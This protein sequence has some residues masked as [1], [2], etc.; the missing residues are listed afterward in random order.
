MCKQ[1]MKNFRTNCDFNV[2]TVKLAFTTIFLHKSI[3][4]FL[5]MQELLIFLPKKIFLAKNM[6]CYAISQGYVGGKWPKQG[7]QKKVSLN[8]HYLL[9]LNCEKRP[10]PL[11]IRSGNSIL[12]ETTTLEFLS[13][14]WWFL[15]HFLIVTLCFGWLVP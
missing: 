11:L 14:L 2:C 1:Y 15:I 7:E 3:F 6:L 10:D 9:L 5:L 12:I 13:T 8:G 4:S